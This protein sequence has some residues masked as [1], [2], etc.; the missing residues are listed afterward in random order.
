MDAK[1]QLG[2]PGLSEE[3]WVGIRNIVDAYTRSNSLNLLALSALH[4]EPAGE[5]PQGT[6]AINAEPIPA[7]P[8][9]LERDEIAPEIWQLLLKINQFGASPDEPGLATLWRHLAHWPNL[10][11][12]IYDALAQLEKEGAMVGSIRY[13]LEVAGREGKR[14]ALLLPDNAEIPEPACTM[15]EKYVTHPGLVARMVAIGNGLS[16]WLQPDSDI[17]YG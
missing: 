6:P 14:L 11:S 10:L 9:L 2:T 17:T 3:A 13:V 7:L 1:K 16:L 5:L 4:V 15:I 12:D 8:A